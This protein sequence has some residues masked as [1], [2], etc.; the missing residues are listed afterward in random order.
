M[1]IAIHT[2]GM[3][4]VTAFHHLPAGTVLLVTELFFGDRAPFLAAA[5]YLPEDARRNRWHGVSDREPDFPAALAGKG[6]PLVDGN[7]FRREK[8][9]RAD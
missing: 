1:A 4:I 7:G 8:F 2:R 5:V 3:K 9:Y 6:I